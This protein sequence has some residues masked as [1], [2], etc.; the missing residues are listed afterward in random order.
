MEL[1]E[2]RVVDDYEEV[3]TPFP[4]T[5][6]ALGSGITTGHI[7]RTPPLRGGVRRDVPAEYRGNRRA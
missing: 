2:I 5:S 1:A 4:S 6:D 7:Y 3:E